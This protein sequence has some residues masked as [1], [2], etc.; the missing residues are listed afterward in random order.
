MNLHKIADITVDLGY[1]YNRLKKQ[2]EAYKI[3]EDSKPDMTIYLSDAFLEQKHKENP[4][5]SV[6]DCEY[7]FTSSVFYTGMLQYGGFMLHSSAVI[8]DGR[9]YLFSAPSGTGKSTHTGLWQ[10]AF[11]EK[12]QILNDDKPAIRAIEDGVFAYGTPW[13]GK[14]DLNIN[15]KAPIA[16]ICFLERS[17]TN[18]I[19]KMDIGSA[20]SALL[21]QTIR[22]F[23][24][25][26]MDLLLGHIEKVLTSVPVYK[27]GCNISEEAA[28]MA[29]NEMS[30]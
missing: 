8:M 6:E 19:E 1:K 13:S 26:D 9:A 20:I 25:H 29:Y 12:V 4:H 22:P 14:T 17:E 18:W 28:I 24:M 10:K 21:N 2:A 23:E 16:G 3:N 5:L 30:K 7:I 11:G 27:M 15:V